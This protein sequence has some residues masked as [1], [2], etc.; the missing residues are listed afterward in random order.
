M[1][2]H[3]FHLFPIRRYEGV[4]IFLTLGKQK[5]ISQTNTIT[6]IIAMNILLATS[7]S[8]RLAVLWALRDAVRNRA[9]K[10]VTSDAFVTIQGQD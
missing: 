8:H 10:E 1:L 2:L 4:L 7:I 3:S 5:R 9:T 6:K